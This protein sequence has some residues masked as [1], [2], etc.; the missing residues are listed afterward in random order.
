MDMCCLRLLNNVVK[1]C[2]YRNFKMNGQLQQNR[3]DGC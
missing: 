1:I 2:I 3:F